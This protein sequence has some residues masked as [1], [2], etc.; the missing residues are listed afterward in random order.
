MTD[1]DLG[2]DFINGLRPVSYKFISG[3][4][5]ADEVDDGFEE[6]ETQVMEIT[7][8]T[9]QVQ[10][11]KEID[12]ELKLVR[13][14]VTK[15]VER[16]VF[17]SIDVVDESGN[18]LETVSVP[19]MQTVKVPKKKQVIRSVPGERIHYGLIAQEVKT[20]MGK[21]SVEDFGG[22]VE[23]EDGT[24]GLR[25]EQFIGPIIKSLQQISERLDKIES[26]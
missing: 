10:E 14:Y 1:S 23:S 17:D 25:Y 11:Q 7:N 13:S 20:L 19:R 8:Q 18:Y 6:I 16:P 4:N 22:Y 3:G 12:G 15:Q 24:L 2:L 5:V 26:K 21:M 9:E